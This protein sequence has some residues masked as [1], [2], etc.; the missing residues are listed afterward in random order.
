MTPGFGLQH[1]AGA[2]QDQRDVLVGHDHHGLQ[3]AQV[4][5]GAPVLG[6]FDRGPGQL[7]RILLELASSRS[8]R[9]KASAVAPA[10]PP[11]TSPLPRIS[12]TFLALALM[13]VWPIETWPS[14]P[15]TTLPPLRTVKIVV[16]CQT[17]GCSRMRA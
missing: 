9:V 8:N 5:V 11:I 10:K 13:T 3:P 2:G 4:A 7:P 16:P 17:G 1:V 6:E 15:I 14:P 12:A